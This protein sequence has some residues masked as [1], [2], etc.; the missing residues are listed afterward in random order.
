MSRI[1]DRIVQDDDGGITLLPPGH[2]KKLVMVRGRNGKL[3]QKI[4]GTDATF[5]DT[6]KPEPPAVGPRNAVLTRSEAAVVLG[7]PI[8]EAARLLD[9][10]ECPRHAAYDGGFVRS[11]T[12]KLRDLPVLTKDK[13]S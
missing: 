3:V 10:W 12:A 5:S 4:A 1:A 9:K 11:L 7:V 2:G 13:P 8:E 6:A